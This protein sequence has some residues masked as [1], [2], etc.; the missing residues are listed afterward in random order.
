MKVSAIVAVSDN[1]I[2]G[3]DNDLPWRLKDDLRYFMQTTKGHHIILGRKNYESIG[4]PLKN[5]TNLIVTRNPYYISTGA[6]TTHS[7]QEA[8]EIAESNGETEAFI[9]GGA[10]IYRLGEPYVDRLYYTRVHAD[11]EGDVYFPD[12]PWEEFN[13]I[14]REEHCADTRNDFDFTFEVYD[15]KQS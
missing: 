5:R 2:I 1:G 7:V 9:V 8:L 4:Y 10:E 15:R 6:I 3:K 11:I 12:W 14:S 13:L